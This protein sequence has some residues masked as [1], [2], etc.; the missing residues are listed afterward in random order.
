[1][2][3]AELAQ[4]AACEQ[5]RGEDEVD[6]L[7]TSE[8]LSRW[9]DSKH[10]VEDWITPAYNIDVA[11]NSGATHQCVHLRSLTVNGKEVKRQTW[12]W[13]D[14]VVFPT[15]FWTYHGAYEWTGYRSYLT[16]AFKQAGQESSSPSTPKKVRLSIEQC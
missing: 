9:S 10:A 5:F 8:F 1:V 11:E 6:W 14:E 4:L 16:R 13:S 12:T 7:S 3:R 15:S 2:A